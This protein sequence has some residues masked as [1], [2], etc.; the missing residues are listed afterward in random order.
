M[1]NISTMSAPFLHNTL[2]AGVC[3]LS[4]AILF[5]LAAVSCTDSDKSF[6]KKTIIQNWQIVDASPALDN[7]DSLLFLINPLRPE[8]DSALYNGLYNSQ[9]V[10]N[11]SVR[12]TLVYDTVAGFRL[13]L[14]RYIAVEV[15]PATLYADVCSD[16]DSIV[17]RFV[18]HKDRQDGNIFK[19][20]E[21]Q[22]MDSL[23]YGKKGM[24]HFTAISP[25]GYTNPNYQAYTFSINPAGF[26]E[27]REICDSL[28]AKRPKALRHK[29]APTLRDDLFSIW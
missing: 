9:Y 22:S 16:S 27:A 12:A 6:E 11:D 10:Q 5:S 13:Y 2:R 24:L 18:M 23:L 25:G 19:I 8:K 14:K 26:K 1:E 3:G 28:N 15:N 17:R 7:P 20:E 4:A 29:T 21:R